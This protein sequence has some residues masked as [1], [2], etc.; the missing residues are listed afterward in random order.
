MRLAG[1]MKMGKGLTMVAV[2]LEVFSCEFR[3]YIRR[4]VDGF[5]QGDPTTP[6]R[7]EDEAIKADLDTFM[8]K[9]GILGFTRLVIMKHDKKARSNNDAM[10]DAS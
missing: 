4:S 2:L 3:N 8:K 10:I 9:E 1:Q 7:S 6:L 5:S